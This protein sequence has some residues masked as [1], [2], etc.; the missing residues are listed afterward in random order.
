MKELLEVEQ[1][2]IVEII[3]GGHFHNEAQDN[4]LRSRKYEINIRLGAMT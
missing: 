4:A 3:S 1:S 2:R